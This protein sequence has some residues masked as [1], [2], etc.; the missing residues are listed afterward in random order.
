M[1]ISLYIQ[2]TQNYHGNTNDKR[3]VFTSF[4]VEQFI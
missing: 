1:S 3:S 4:E 2:D